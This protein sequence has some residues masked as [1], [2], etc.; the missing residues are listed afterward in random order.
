MTKRVKFYRGFPA[1]QTKDDPAIMVFHPAVI[2]SIT[3]GLVG[4]RIVWGQVE[5]PVTRAIRNVRSV[6]R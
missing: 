2:R 1:M 3:H 5:N 4:G 6:L